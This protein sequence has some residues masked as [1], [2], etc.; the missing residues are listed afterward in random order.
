MVRISSKDFYVD[1]FV[2]VE[3]RFIELKYFKEYSNINQNMYSLS[4]INT[5]L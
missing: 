2:A 5:E 1:Y 4:T 3:I